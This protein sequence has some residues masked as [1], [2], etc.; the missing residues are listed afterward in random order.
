MIAAIPIVALV[1]I[2][3]DRSTTSRR[4]TLLLQYLQLSGKLYGLG[5]HC[6]PCILN[7]VEQVTQR[8][9]LFA[10]YLL[11]IFHLVLTILRFFLQQ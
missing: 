11:R 5:V 8:F 2:G 10:K 3:A 9:A 4:C 1:D 7:L 6:W